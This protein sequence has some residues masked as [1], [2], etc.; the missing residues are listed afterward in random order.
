ML[1]ASDH[2]PEEIKEVRKAGI[3]LEDRFEISM[4]TLSPKFT[5]SPLKLHENMYDL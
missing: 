3:M 1:N 5:L 2:F 4:C